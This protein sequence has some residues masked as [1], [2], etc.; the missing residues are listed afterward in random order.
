MAKRL[1]RERRLGDEGEE[2]SQ[3]GLDMEDLN[4]TFWMQFG[5]RKHFASHLSGVFSFLGFL[6]HLTILLR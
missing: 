6:A 2:I 5:K 1:K 3:E 4:Q